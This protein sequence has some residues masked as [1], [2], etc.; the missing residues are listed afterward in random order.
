MLAADAGGARIPAYSYPENAARAL[1]HA[2]G[3]REW[4]DAQHGQVPEFEDVDIDAAARSSASFAETW[5][6]V[7]PL[8]PF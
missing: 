7:G 1:A 8:R 2:A 5:G 6:V 3:Y 4:R